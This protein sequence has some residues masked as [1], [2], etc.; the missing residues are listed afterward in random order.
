MSTFGIV[1]EL[2]QRCRELMRREQAA[3]ARAER[4][5]ADLSMAIKVIA[6]LNRPSQPE[7]RIAPKF[8]SPG[9]PRED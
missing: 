6:A 5:E 4:A 7:F 2:H 1:S 3:I 8:V 9:L